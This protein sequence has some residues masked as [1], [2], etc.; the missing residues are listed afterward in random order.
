MKVVFAGPSLYPFEGVR[1]A[2]PADITWNGPARQGD[3]ARAVH[4]GACAIALIDG[5]Y[6]TIASVW[7]KEL[8]FALERGLRVIG[9]A[10]LGAIRAAECAPF[11]MEG[12]GTIFNRYRSGDL[13]DDGAV[14]LLHAPAELGYA[15]LTETLVDM[16]ATFAS[17]AY[18]R[19][20]TTAEATRLSGC[21]EAMFFGDRTSDEVVARAGFRGVEATRLSTLIETHRVR[22][23]RQDALRV[24]DRLMALPSDLSRP[25]HGWVSSATRSYRMLSRT[26]QAAD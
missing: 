17:L 3:I 24:L 25:A 19:L 7:H 6:G 15:P 9:G 8:L 10:S 13:I 26:T 18:M 20:L 23:K 16:Q 21:A 11:G 4:N 2:Y 14:A 12:V 1:A 5:L 22:L